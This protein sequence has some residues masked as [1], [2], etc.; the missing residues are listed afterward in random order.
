MDN[1]TELE[2]SLLEVPLVE[3][4]VRDCERLDYVLTLDSA[5]AHTSSRYRF[6]C[7]RDGN[8]KLTFIAIGPCAREISIEVILEE[9]GAQATIHGCYAL[10]GTMQHHITLV[11]DHQAPHTKSYSMVQCALAG[12]ALFNYHGI[13]NIAQ[14]AHG[15]DAALY[16]K[17]VLLSHTARAVAM[18][19]L[20]VHTNSV[21]CKH[22]TATSSFNDDQVVYL[23]SR[24]I[25][26]QKAK[27]LLI[28]GFFSDEFNLTQEQF[29]RITHE[30]L[31]C[32]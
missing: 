24:G 4:I 1:A 22:G 10:N 30:L 27:E 5:R 20:E 3:I 28:R 17:N 31:I 16:N 18:P 13:I 12:E 21:Q 8:L 19:S 23:K 6:V 9:E 26:E 25:D 7:K 14:R 29:A 32:Q 15:T 11:Q 2:P